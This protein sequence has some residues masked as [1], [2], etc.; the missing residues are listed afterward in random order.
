MARP[1]VQSAAGSRDAIAAVQPGP[2]G[3]GKPPL[4]PLCE[5]WMATFSKVWSSELARAA[6][7]STG[8]W[9]GSPLGGSG[10]AVLE[11]GRGQDD[12]EEDE[13]EEGEEGRAVVHR[14]GAKTKFIPS[15]K[16]RPTRARPWVGLD[17]RVN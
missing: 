12:E 14:A 8:T 11:D 2:L 6:P 13:G 15:W 10:R 7:C 5:A 9:S 3:E 4:W 17:S 16:P 1:A